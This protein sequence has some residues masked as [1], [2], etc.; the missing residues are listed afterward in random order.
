MYWALWVVMV[1]GTIKE[2]KDEKNAKK[3]FVAIVLIMLVMAA[4]RYGQG[5]DYFTYELWYNRQI[6]HGV[7]IGYVLLT[8]LLYQ[9]GIP[10][11]GC[12]AVIAAIEMLCFYVFIQKYSPYKLVSVLLLYPT[13]YLTYMFSLIRQ[14]LALAVFCGIAIPFL[15]E[16]KYI[17]YCMG[18]LLAASFHQ[19]ALILLVLPI[20]LKFRYKQLALLTIP[21]A[22]VGVGS[23]LIDLRPLMIWFLGSRGAYYAAT[24]GNTDIS[25]MGIVERTLMIFVIWW[26]SR[27]YIS[28]IRDEKT[29]LNLCRIY[30]FGYILSLLAVRY[31][32]L[33]SRL[34]AY[35][36]ITELVLIPRLMVEMDKK[37]RRI[38]MGLL[39]LYSFLFLYKN[40]W[41]YIV[42]SGYQNVSVWTYPWITVFTKELA[43]F[44]V[45]FK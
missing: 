6:T 17:K 13:I 38:V 9:A 12:I 29:T 31:Q 22:I 26:A 32:L 42:Q 7:E 1:I 37:T 30:T 3:W 19:T 41:S 44:R 15:M 5:T 18:V 33:S 45:I 8:G 24:W 4:L 2:Q 28:G 40:I 21:A 39:I 20:V 16:K 23:C 25:I 35:C 14:S 43:V 36:K 10:F 27:Q 34:G 11:A